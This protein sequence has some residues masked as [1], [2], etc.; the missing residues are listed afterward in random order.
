MTRAQ[1]IR[2]LLSGL[3][4]QWSIAKCSELRETMNERERFLTHTVQEVWAC[5]W[6]TPGN[7]FFFGGDVQGGSPWGAMGKDSAKGHLLCPVSYFEHFPGKAWDLTE[8]LITWAEVTLSFH[9]WLVCMGTRGGRKQNDGSCHL[10]TRERART[11]DS[12][13]TGVTTNSVLFLLTEGA[14]F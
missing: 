3:C 7:E 13:A 9:P 8:A 11:S 2:Q 4:L 14:W 10:G 12:L 1:D 6:V 5:T